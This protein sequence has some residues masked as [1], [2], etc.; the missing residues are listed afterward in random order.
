MES[1]AVSIIKFLVEGQTEFVSNL[2]PSGPIV[3]HIVLSRLLLND[4][5]NLCEKVLFIVDVI[6]LIHLWESVPDQLVLERE[7]HRDGDTR[8]HADWFLLAAWQ[9]GEVHVHLGTWELN[10]FVERANDVPAPFVDLGHIN[11]F[12]ECVVLQP[13]LNWLDSSRTECQSNDAEHDHCDCA[14]TTASSLVIHLDF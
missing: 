4:T 6:D 10:E 8:A 11:V 2:F 3:C 1:G 13:V 9:I 12:G 7:R 14:N 5:F